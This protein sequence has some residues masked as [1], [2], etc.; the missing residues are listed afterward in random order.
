MTA[1][2]RLATP[3]RTLDRWTAL[4]AK[5]PKLS[6]TARRYLAQ[7]EVSMSRATME[8]T[9]EVLASFCAYLVAEHPEVNSFADVGRLYIE[10]YKAHLAR[11]TAPGGTPLKPNT[12]RVH[13]TMVRVFFDRIIEWGYPDAPAF[14]P[15]FRADLPKVP[16]P[17]PK[18]LDDAASA[19]F[20]GGRGPR[21]RPLPP[22]MPGDPG[23]HGHACKRAVHPERG[24]PPVSLGVVV[25][26][27]PGGQAAQ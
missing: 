14:T 18:A 2:A 17:L 5:A 27:G 19:R 12:R 8:K 3:E 26:Q 21:P 11:R 1:P 4:R 15:V 16:E 20:F 13:L 24:R 7:I 23:P 22:T 9:D 10:A 6:S 25:G